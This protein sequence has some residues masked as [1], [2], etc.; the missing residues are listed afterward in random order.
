MH[1]AEWA[2][3]EGGPV[4]DPRRPAEGLDDPTE[5]DE[6]YDDEL[7]DLGSLDMVPDDDEA[8]R[9][10]S[11]PEW[12]A[13]TAIEM[14]ISGA[15]GLY[16]SVTLS[17]EA[18]QLAGDPDAVFPCDVNAWISCGTVARSWQATLLGFPNAFLGILF[19]A[20]VL[21]ISVALLGRTVFPRW[22]MNCAQ[23]LYTVALFF[24]LWLFSQS[25][26]VIKVLCPWCLLI[27]ATTTLVWAGL[28]RINIR[29]GNLPS[30]PGMRRFIV[31]GNDWFVVVAFLVVLA[32]MIVVKYGP[33]ILS[34]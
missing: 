15:L 19:E 2:D 22:F 26:F 31:A 34:H 27:A 25:Y 8:L 23:A 4:D 29:D 24:A 13:R 10:P 33:L 12:R 21:T 17:I 11:T 32:G 1:R 18:W 9:R 7:D 20:V 30:T 5:L 6:A 28:T 3:D 14:A 16:A